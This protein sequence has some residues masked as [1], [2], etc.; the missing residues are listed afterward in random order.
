MK[1][2]K[3]RIERALGFVFG[4][5]KADHPAD[6]RVMLRIAAGGDRKLCIFE[7]GVNGRYVYVERAPV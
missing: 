4:I 7:A 5:A 3:D 1:D 6:F 2:I